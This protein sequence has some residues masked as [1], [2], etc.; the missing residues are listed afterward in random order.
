[1]PTTYDNVIATTSQ[2]STIAGAINRTNIPYSTISLVPNIQHRYQLEVERIFT[3][4]LNGLNAGALVIKQFLE[5]P[6]VN[7]EVK[8]NLFIIPASYITAYN[9]STKQLTIV[10]LAVTTYTYVVTGT[11][12]SYSIPVPPIG[13]G[14][15]ITVRR[16]TISNTPLVSWTAG[17]KLTSNQLNLMTTQ[18]LYLQQE[19]LDRVFYQAILSG[20]SVTALNSNSVSEEKLTTNS[21]STIKIQDLAVTNDKIAL[22]EITYDRIN[23]TTSPWAVDLMNT[24][25]ITGSKKFSN[26]AIIGAFSVYPYPVTPAGQQYVLAYTGSNDGATGGVSLTLNNPWNNL[27]SYILR[28]DTDQT[29]TGNKTISGNT[30]IQGTLKI[31]GGNPAVNKVLTATDIYGATTWTPTVSGIRLGS[32]SAEISTGTVIITPESI[33]A[34][35]ASGGTVTGNTVFSGNVNLGTSITQNIEV[36][37]TLKYRPGNAD[38]VNGKIL[39]TSNAGVISLQDVPATGITK[40]QMGGVDYSTSTVAITADLLGAVDKNSNQTIGGNKTFSDN[41]VL[42]STS[43]K[44][45]S[46]ISPLSYKP[47]GQT[48]PTTGMVLTAN[49]NSG[50]MSWQPLDFTNANVVTSFNNSVGDIDIEIPTAASIIAAIPTATGGT[51]GLV[52]VGSGLKIDSDVLSIDTTGVTLPTATTTTLGAIKIGSGLSINGSGEVSVNGL[53]TGTVPVTSWKTVGGTARTGD[54]V[55]AAND[56]T[57][58]PNSNTSVTNAVDTITAQ[59]ITAIKTFKAN[60]I[61]TADASPGVGDSGKSGIQLNTTGQIKAQRT[62]NFDKVFTSYNPT[63]NETASIDGWGNSVFK[64]T[65]SADLGFI[66]TGGVTLG[67]TSSDSIVLNGTVRVVPNAVKDYVLTCTTVTVAN[68]TMTCSIA[69]TT[70]T[71]T[72]VS[73]T[74]INGMPI[75]GGTIAPLTKITGFL[76]GTGGTG[77]YTV[78]KSQT[79]NSTAGIVGVNPN[80]G[81]AEWKTIPNAPVTSVNGLTNVV[82][83][84]TGNIKDEATGLIN[85]PVVSRE[86]EETIT[87][88]KTFSASPTGLIVTNA[89]IFNGNMTIGSDSADIC[90]LNAT[91]QATAAQG[92]FGINKVLMSDTNGKI[93]LGN[94]LV[95]S[96]RGTNNASDW[97]GRLGNVVLTAADVGAAST[98]ELAT[99]NLAVTAAK[100][101]ADQAYGLANTANNLAGTKLSIVNTQPTVVN[102]ITYTTLGG[103][104]TAEDKLYV[105]QAF[106]CGAATGDL[107]GFYP[108]PTV[109]ANKITYAKMQ[110]VTAGRLLGAR[111]AGNVVEISLGDGLAF[112]TSNNILKCTIASSAALLTAAGTT[113]QLPQ[114]WGG[115]NAFTNATAF[116]STISAPNGSITGLGLS[117][118]S[119]ITATTTI[120]AGQGL[121]ATTG[122]LTVVAGGIGVTAGG[123]TVSAGDVTI[124]SATVS[125]AANSG[126]L[127]VTGGVGIGG[128]VNIAGALNVTSNI[129]GTLATAAQTNI[130][131]V[132]TLSGGSIPLSLTTGTLPATSGGTGQTT[133]AVGDL[134]YCSATDTLTK[135]VKP[136]VTS[137]LQMT[138]GGTPSWTTAIPFTIPNVVILVSSGYT[139]SGGQYYSTYQSSDTNLVAVST[140]ASTNGSAFKCTFTGTWAFTGYIEQTSATNNRVVINTGAIVSGANIVTGAQFYVGSVVKSE[141]MI[142]GI[143]RS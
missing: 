74:I 26:L 35:S 89:A 50:S 39:M 17:T 115:Y 16:K 91:L 54:V 108:D 88:K 78:N 101:R 47:A 2:V 104:G 107:S 84:T 102:N 82:Q 96:V 41:T 14:D 27:P 23:T 6:L 65:V 49:G 106:P 28:T 100:D 55:A 11:G 43:G 4:D 85:T 22:G 53:T 120:T 70:L 109:G 36:Q 79:V 12:Y 97:A 140:Q 86:N 7:I 73:G 46:I 114:T 124:S 125:S 8:R 42:G 87:G 119:S 142:I 105:L 83:I 94:Q 57:A 15:K 37:G 56:Y 75:T 129:Y 127:K 9:E 30:T 77:T 138:S 103:T 63:G 61:V 95:Q 141:S 111:V 51:R 113:A 58:T 118:T 126:A 139:I 10:D 76:S 122:G 5:D 48:D 130:T 69:D 93:A 19:V 60:Q 31:N 29:I 99:T 66:T 121:T 134:L 72:V 20:D 137:F 44:T 13:S 32:S 38:P 110:T 1:M 132:G 128:T 117:S 45:V 123:L 71:V 24:Q 131:S 34:L 98:S 62:S 18:L 64:G 143:K 136:T 25:Q 92:S 67:D 33:G 116:N 133:Y 59:N 90:T 135:L 81:T 68:I 112:D 21:V 3:N 40:I 80:N 52:K